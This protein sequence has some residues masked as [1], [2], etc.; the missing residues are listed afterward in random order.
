MLSRSAALIRRRAVELR[1]VVL[2]RCA[3]RGSVKGAHQPPTT[4][5]RTE[6]KTLVDAGDK[7]CHERTGATEKVFRGEPSAAMSVLVSKIDAFSSRIDLSAA[8]LFA[9]IDAANA[10][11]AAANALTAAKIDVAS[12][13]T[14]AIARFDVTIAKIDPINTALT[15]IRVSLFIV[16]AILVATP[17]VAPNVAE[18][19]GA[20]KKA[21][22]PPSL[23]YTGSPC[24]SQVAGS[25]LSRP[26]LS[27]PLAL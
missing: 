14:A 4:V 13:Q 15:A 3:H 8:K 7:V 19:C 26:H 20:V 18:R 12:A 25:Q 21:Q 27:V 10:Q 22:P 9:A 5:T 1:P 16:F 11:T 17:F 23:T 24:G 2:R 6:V